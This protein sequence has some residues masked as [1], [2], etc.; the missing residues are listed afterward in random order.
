[1]AA[2]ARKTERLE[3]A[4]TMIAFQLGGEAGFRLAH[5]LGS[6]VSPDALLERIRRMSC[7][8][9]GAGGG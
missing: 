7:S 3:E 8:G 9:A 5:G 1:V 6:L 2:Q 4:L